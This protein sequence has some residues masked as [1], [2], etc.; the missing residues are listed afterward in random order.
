MRMRYRGWSIQA[1]PITVYELTL[2]KFDADSV[3]LDVHC[4]KRT[5]IR[6]II[7]DLG[8]LLG[9]NFQLIPDQKPTLAS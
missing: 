9:C 3:M 4:S 6:T 2:L 5:Y 7:D 1:R 8:E